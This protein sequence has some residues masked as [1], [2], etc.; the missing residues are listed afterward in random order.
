MPYPFALEP[1]RRL[2]P[3]P[4]AD[5]SA[6]FIHRPIVRPYG[7]FMKTRCFLQFWLRPSSLAVKNRRHF[8]FFLVQHGSSVK[9]PKALLHFL[10]KSCGVAHSGVADEK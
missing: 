6:F 4:L 9:G 5:S 10:K 1:S 2:R 8:A 7:G 3:P